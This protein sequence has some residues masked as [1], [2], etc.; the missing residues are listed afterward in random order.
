MNWLAGEPPHVDGAEVLGWW[1]AS[2]LYHVIEW[3]DA[4][5][6]W[7]ETDDRCVMNRPTHYVLLQPPT[8]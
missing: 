6:A 5:Q 1:S 8:V 7:I 3:S 2:K 4:D